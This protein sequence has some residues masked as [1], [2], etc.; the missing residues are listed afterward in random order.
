MRCSWCRNLLWYYNTT[1][2]RRLLA[3]RLAGGFSPS[4]TTAPDRCCRRCIVR[5]KHL[6]TLDNSVTT[7]AECVTPTHPPSHL[8]I[9]FWSLVE[10]SR[11]PVGVPAR[12]AH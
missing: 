9:S 12:P 10:G 1:T 2:D 8:I 4:E 11:R 3:G 7:Q 6:T 5:R